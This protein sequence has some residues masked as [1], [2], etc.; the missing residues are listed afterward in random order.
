MSPRALD[1]IFVSVALFGALVSAYY[2]VAG[3]LHKDRLLSRSA[4]AAF[5]GFCIAAVVYLWTV[6]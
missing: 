5:L 4:A 3:V 6:L 1:F 2:Y